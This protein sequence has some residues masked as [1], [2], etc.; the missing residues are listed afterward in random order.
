MLVR[1]PVTEVRRANS[2]RAI[3]AI[4][5]CYVLTY[6]TVLA[7]ALSKGRD[8]FDPYDLAVWAVSALLVF[9]LTGAIAGLVFACF[10]FRTSRAPIAFAVWIATIGILGLGL[11]LNGH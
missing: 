2:R 5:S 6:A 8:I 3:L 7:L 11:V 9:I 4:A 1:N 10:S